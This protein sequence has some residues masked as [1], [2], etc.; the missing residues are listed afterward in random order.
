[1]NSYSE[2]VLRCVGKAIYLYCGMVIAGDKDDSLYLEDDYPKYIQ[3]NE[4]IKIVI[5]NIWKTY[6]GYTVY[7]KD[8]IIFSCGF[9]VAFNDDECFLRS[10]LKAVKL[11]Q[12][13]DMAH[14]V[15]RSLEHWENDQFIRHYNETRHCEDSNNT[16]CL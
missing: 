4:K 16:E 15:T 5:D 8:V 12:Y 11:R 3:V 2:N 13:V 10:T 7:C 1:M 6:I 14:Y 9:D